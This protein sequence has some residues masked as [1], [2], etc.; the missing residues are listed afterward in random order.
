V[1]GLGIERIEVLLLVAAIVA[2]LARR[3]RLPYTV[4]LVSAGVALALS[5]L[6]LGVTLTR[7]LVFVAFLP[8]LIFEAA[9]HISAKELRRDLAVLA[10]LATLGVVLSGAVVAS[11][12]R[13]LGGW[14]WS[15][16][17]LFGAL[18]SATDPV[19]VIATLRQA[20]AHGRL[21]LLAEAESLLN[22]GTAAVAFGLVLAATRGEGVGP[23]AIAGS[24]VTTV[25][26]GVLCGG[27]VAGGAL[28]LVGRTNDHL[29]EITFT[30]V[31]AWGSFLL[32]EHYHV[33]GVLATLTAG[34]LIGNLGALGV[35]SP[36]GRETVDSFWDYAA[37]VVNSL[38]FLLIGMSLVGPNLSA[39]ALGAAFAIPLVLLGRGVSVYACCALFLRS[40][41]R[42]TRPHQHILFWGG[43]RGAL[44]LA[45][46][47]GLPRDLPHREQAITVAF[48]VVAFSVVVQGLTMTPLLRRLGEIGQPPEGG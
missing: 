45:L 4:G 10:V 46:A 5:P 9:L 42:V 22:D 31:A 23:A 34:L 33:S 37:F 2:M 15:T 16:A 41:L 1:A 18:I 40:S 20:G 48:A 3:L 8:P 11:G 14:G 19:S 28:L 36:R 30:T 38:I 17:L 29:V 27:L 39:S 47:L 7:E 35:I 6:S 13:L 12:M 24:F 25:A 32:A 26:G 44:A 43:L 21:R